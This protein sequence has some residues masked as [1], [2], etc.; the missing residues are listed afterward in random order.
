M[1][2]K[3]QKTTTTEAKPAPEQVPTDTKPQP[4]PSVRALMYR[5]STLTKAA[6][7]RAADNT[8]ADRAETFGFA[9]RE[10]ENAAAL[11]WKHHART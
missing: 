9:L 6:A 4:V 8:G 7:K 3:K 1:K 2:T 5:I 10:I 11:Y